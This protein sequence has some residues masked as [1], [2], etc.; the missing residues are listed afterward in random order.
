MTRERQSQIENGPGKFDLAAALFKG[1]PVRFSLAWGGEV[2]A[3]ITSAATIGQ[4]R[5]RWLLRGFTG[6]QPFKA[7]YNVRTRRGLFDRVKPDEL[8]KAVQKL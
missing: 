1:D 6:E 5:D 4:D 3:K 2:Q 7:Q 8:E